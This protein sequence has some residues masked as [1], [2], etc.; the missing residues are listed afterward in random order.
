MHFINKYVFIHIYL[1]RVINFVITK[2]KRCKIDV[3]Q[4]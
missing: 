1:Y 3:C 4:T 2:V